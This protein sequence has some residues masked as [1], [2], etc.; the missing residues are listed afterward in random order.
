M[1]DSKITSLPTQN[2]CTWRAAASLSFCQKPTSPHHTYL[3]P[4]RLSLGTSTLSSLPG[5][6]AGNAF[7][8]RPHRRPLTG[9]NCDPSSSL[10]F[11][12]RVRRAASGDLETESNCTRELS[13]ACDCTY[14]RPPP[15]HCLGALYPGGSEDV[16][17]RLRHGQRSR[18]VK[19]RSR[20]G[21][22]SSPSPHRCDEAG[23]DGCAAGGLT[24]RREEFVRD[25]AGE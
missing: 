1:K 12:K 22:A 21:M 14:D 19:N 6:C 4:A 18:R 7:Q 15:R 8:G 9:G 10:H 16:S 11:D 20:R 24:G 17:L 25:V 3:A 13:H 2:F 5:A 23:E